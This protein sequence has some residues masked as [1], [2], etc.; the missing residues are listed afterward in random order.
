MLLALSFDIKFVAIAQCSILTVRKGYGRTE[1]VNWSLVLKELICKFVAEFTI[2]PL[3]CEDH[4]SG[5]PGSGRYFL[6][7]II[8]LRFSYCLIAYFNCNTLILFYT[9]ITLYHLNKRL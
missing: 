4:F 3:W 6:K 2:N 7:F 1:P 9:D 8:V 5:S